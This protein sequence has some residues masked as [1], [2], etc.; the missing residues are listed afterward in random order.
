MRTGRTITQ[1]D[2]ACTRAM[3]A[4]DHHEWVNSA[5][6]DLLLG[7]D[8]LWQIMASTWTGNGLAKEE[9]EKIVKPI[10]VLLA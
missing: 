3:T 10:R 1:I 2:D 9:A 7:G 5:A 8:T 6:K 4:A